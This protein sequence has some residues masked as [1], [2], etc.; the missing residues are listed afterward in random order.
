[1][2]DI[3]NSTKLSYYQH[4]LA[5]SITCMG[6]GLH[7]GLPVEMT[8]LPADPN[9]GYVFIRRDVQH[10]PQEVIARWYTVENTHLSTTVSNDMGIRVT[11]IEHLL[12]ALHACG[13]DNARI[14][15]NAQEVP[16]MDGSSETFMDMIQSVGAEKQLAQR[17]AIVVE[18]DVS[19]WEKNRSVSFGPSSIPWINVEIDFE[20]KVIGNQKLSRPLTEEVFRSEICRSRTFGFE[21][22]VETLKQFGFAQGGSLCNS[23]LISGSKV[24]N[25][26]GLRSDDEFVRHKYLD[27]VG[28]M[29][30]AGAHIIGQF[31]GYCSGHR[32]NNLLLRALMASEDARSY[33]TLQE[34][35][36]YWDGRMELRV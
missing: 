34:A 20:S 12:A 29:A 31:N 24:M 23:I 17:W 32:I 14:A 11:T 27:A 35:E 19:V 30:L 16:I 1:M 33:M 3:C 10:G 9:T 6:R 18:Q 4:T 36:T 15:I 25:E 28:D 22:Q 26:E 7:L 21:E 5:D 13:I 2:N 8:L